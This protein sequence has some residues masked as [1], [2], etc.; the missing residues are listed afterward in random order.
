MKKDNSSLQN[1]PIF[2]QMRETQLVHYWT[3]SRQE[4]ICEMEI[5]FLIQ[6]VV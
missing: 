3:A 5:F 6:Y 1:D 4:S 2:K